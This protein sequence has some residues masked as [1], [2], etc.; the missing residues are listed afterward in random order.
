MPELITGL[1][2]VIYMLIFMLG[3][4]LAFYILYLNHSIHIQIQILNFIHMAKMTK[5]KLSS[6][7]SEIMSA[8]KRVRKAHPKMKW[9]DCVKKAAKEFKRKKS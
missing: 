2:L 8:A 5:K 4:Y 7:G 3:V 1:I 9:Q 6:M